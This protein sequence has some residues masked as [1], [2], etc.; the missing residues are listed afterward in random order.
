MPTTAMNNTVIFLYNHDAAHQV[1][2]SAGIAGAFALRGHLA[3]AATANADIRAELEKLLTPEQIASLVWL[4][5]ALPSWLQILLAPMNRLFPVRRLA[6][7]YWH[8]KALRQAA[9]IVS[10]E[11]TC[12][13]LKRH[14]RGGPSPRFILVPHGAGDRNVT[15]HPAYKDF[16]LFLLS[17]Q[18]VVDQFVGSGLATADQCRIIGYAKFDILRGRTPEKFFDNDLPTFLYNPHFDPHMSSWFDLGPQILEWFYNR[19][20]QYNLIFAPHV[21]LFFKKVHISPEFKVTRTRPDIHEKYRSAP[22]MLIDVDSQRLFDMSYTFSSDA[23]IGDVSSQVYE[24]LFRPRPCFFID[25]HSESTADAPP[26][27]DFWRNGPVVRTVQELAAVIPAYQAIGAQYRDIQIDRMGYTA[28]ITD[29]RPA[30][31][32]GATALFD[33]IGSLTD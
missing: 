7:L 29:P 24:F 5:L 11:R 32:R 18:K 21:M 4:D 12:L 15:T 8:R 26:A 14:W 27:Y 28:D 16:D 10:T 17:G 3:V 25:V 2:H 9:A 19:A 30:S 33:Y 6:R 1:A 23:Y 20:D 31:Q 22:N 13:T